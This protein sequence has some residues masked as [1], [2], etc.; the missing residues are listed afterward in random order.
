MNGVS[1]TVKV[2]RA[3]MRMESGKAALGAV[4][5]MGSP[6]VAEAMA[7]HFD[8]LLIDAQHGDWSIESAWEAFRRVVGAGGVPLV[9]VF[10]NDPF[11]IGAML[12]RGALGIVVPMVETEEEARAVADA[13]RYGPRGKRSVGGGGLRNWLPV[14]NEEINDEIFVAVQ[15]ETKLGVSNAEAILSVDGVDGCWIGPDDLAL[16]LDVDRTTEVGRQE[17]EEAIRSVLQACQKTGKIPGIATPGPNNQWLEAGCLFVT[18]GSEG[19]CI[20][21]GAAGTLRAY[22]AYRPS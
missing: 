7:R 22:E 14:S 13:A 8:F 15:I 2:N 18:V 6:A 5:G 4:L 10:R 20:G 11:A 3:K 17:H 21:K 19:S 16:S 1:A 12:D 9:R